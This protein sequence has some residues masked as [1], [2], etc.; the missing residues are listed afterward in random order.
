MKFTANRYADAIR[1]DIVDTTAPI[2]L[3]ATADGA[4]KFDEFTFYVAWA[5]TEA[6]CK[7]ICYDA[8][9]GKAKISVMRKPAANGGTEQWHLWNVYWVKRNMPNTG[10]ASCD[11]FMDDGYNAATDTGIKVQFDLKP[12]VE[13]A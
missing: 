10:T 9:D 12:T 8:V 2:N 3:A 13:Y 6:S 7:A 1:A 11:G 4:E 5:S